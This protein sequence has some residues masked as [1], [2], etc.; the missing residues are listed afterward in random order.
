MK[1]FVP[2]LLLATVVAAEP[3]PAEPVQPWDYTLAK[4]SAERIPRWLKLSGEFRSRFEGRTGF[5]YEPDNDDYYALFRVRLNINIVP[6]SWLAVSFEGQDARVSGIN[7]GR[8]LTTF[9]NP[10]D[11]RQAYI[12][13]GNANG[14]IK[15]TVGRQLL[16]FGAQ[17]LLGPLDW[18]NTS[19][20]WDAAR[21]D[22]GTAN[23]SVALFASTVVQPDPT[24]RI[25]QPRRGF[26]IHG[27]YGSIKSLIPKTVF[28]PYLLYK[29]GGGSGVT[30][31]GV[32][33]ASLPSLKGYDYQLETA[34]QYGRYNYLAHDAWS[35][36]IVGGKTLTAKK[37]TPRF[38]AE[39]SAASG[40]DNPNDR[41]HTTFDHLLGTNHLFYGLVDAVGW[42]NMR[43]VRLGF[44][45][46]PH[47]RVQFVTDYHW[48]WL[49]SAND[50]LYDV[51]GRATIRPK[52]GNTARDIGRE[53][54]FTVNWAASRQWK[55]GGGVGHL[56]A[57][58]YIKQNSKGSGQTFSYL[59]TQYS[60]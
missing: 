13:L 40:D 21:L 11:V 53:L 58:S 34:R 42:Q 27:A 7:P 59:F 28:E 56:F 37:W 15:L 60:F 4:M 49:G 46:K 6:T 12:R 39:Y 35:F 19:R 2:F 57:G 43:N 51:A 8:P 45:A 14:P 32:R 22:I 25:D 52:A 41:H 20:N 31:A 23:A 17:R 3:P 50:A 16:N 29:T 1:Q 24:R 10:A 36:S 47:K 55:I 54:D 5:N 44:D 38:S 30:T 18:T 33:F 26:N 48:L 9:E